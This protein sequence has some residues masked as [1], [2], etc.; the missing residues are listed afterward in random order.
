M[1]IVLVVEDEARIAGLLRRTLEND[2]H[3]VIVASGGREALRVAA[4][5]PIDLVVLDL[6][7]PDLPG[8]DVA[9][10]LRRNGPVPILM[11]T[12]KASERDRIAGLSSHS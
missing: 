5:E 12:A 2:G 1:G 7:L 8:E 6:R 9:R 4:I 10:E 3:T 11:L